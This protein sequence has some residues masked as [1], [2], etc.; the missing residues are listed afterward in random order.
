[1]NV[2]A[3][4]GLYFRLSNT[5]KNQVKFVRASDSSVGRFALSV[6]SLVCSIR[7]DS[8]GTGHEPACQNQI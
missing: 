5:Q 4:A 8:K 1:M 6:V 3:N 7:F 2:K